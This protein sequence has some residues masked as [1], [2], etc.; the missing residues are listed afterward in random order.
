MRRFDTV[1]SLLPILAAAG[2]ISPATSAL[3]GGF[4]LSEQSVP[5]LG[6]AYTGGAAA[7]DASTIFSIQL[8]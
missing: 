4:A 1:H 8:D 7:E 5:G 6:N 3:A 2:M